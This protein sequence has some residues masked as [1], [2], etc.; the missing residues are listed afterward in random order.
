MSRKRNKMSTTER[1]NQIL[2]LLDDNVYISVNEL[3]RLMFTSPSSIRRD[4]TH[5]QNLGYVKRSYGGVSSAEI[6]GQVAG[7]YNRTEKNVKEKRIIAEKAASLLR[8]GQSILLDS[9]TTA[10]FILPYVARLD[11]ATVFTNNLETA[12]SAIKQGIRTHCIGGGAINGSVSL[13]GAEAYRA[14]MDINVDIL[15]FS[16]QSL[17]L[18][19]IISDS[20][21]EENFI[22][23]IMLDRAQKTVF[24]C[25]STKFNTS[26]LYTLA[27]LDKINFAVFDKEFEG[28][29]TTSC[30]L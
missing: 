3:S 29:R 22:R 6:N 12:I 18:D 27:P 26:S 15:F 30:V 8:N 5:L 10:S 14:L 20:T 19:G 9:S 16:S 28:L 4:L 7:F 13:G 23:R 21:E 17:S 11:S 2:K 25:D 1:Q 24:L